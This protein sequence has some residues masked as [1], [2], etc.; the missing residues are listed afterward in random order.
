L[1]Y[2]TVSSTY[3][4]MNVF[5]IPNPFA[6]G[7]H[8]TFTLLG[9]SSPSSLQIKIYTVAGRAIRAL[10]IPASDVRIGFNKIAWDGRDEDGSEIANG[11]YFFRL[12]IDGE[13]GKL[14]V[15]G[16]LMKMR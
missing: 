12:V 6:A 7:T 3:S 16:K 15:T 13:S 11:I 2:L 1:L 8:F 4:L 10:K 5:P 14:G 9:A